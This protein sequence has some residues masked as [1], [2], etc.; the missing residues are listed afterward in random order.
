MAGV[1]GDAGYVVYREDGAE[2]GIMLRWQGG[3]H[4]EYLDEVFE[5]DY[6]CVTGQ[7]RRDQ[8]AV[9]YLWDAHTSALRRLAAYSRRMPVRKPGESES[10][11]RAR[12]NQ[13][14]A[15]MEAE[16]QAALASIRGEQPHTLAA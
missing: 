16:R 10:D 14:H 9:N 13:A 1:L 6:V 2:L 12:I 8:I 5:G 7:A 3:W 11:H 4:V 15:E